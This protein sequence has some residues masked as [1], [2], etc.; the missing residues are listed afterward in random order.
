MNDCDGLNCGGP[1]RFLTIFIAN[2]FFF[3]FLGGLNKDPTHRVRLGS[4]GR[5]YRLDIG[6]QHINLSL[7]PGFQSI[8]LDT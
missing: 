2:S 6:L 1:Y 4:E 8:F 5:N 3:P 7:S